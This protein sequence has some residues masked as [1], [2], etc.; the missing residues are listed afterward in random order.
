MAPATPFDAFWIFQRCGGY[1]VHVS[2]ICEAAT[3]PELTLS[4]VEKIMITDAHMHLIRPFDLEGNPQLYLPGALT[5]AKDYV[6]LMDEVGIER[7]FFISWSPEDISADIL[8]RGITVESLH[9]VMNREY[10]L[11]AMRAF[12][13]R[14][15]WF[16]CHLNP[17]TGDHLDIARE[18]LELGATGLKLAPS[19]WGELPD[20]PRLIPIYELAQDYGAQMIIDTSFWSLDEPVDPETFPPEHRIIADNLRSLQDYLKR[21]WAVVPAPGHREVAKRVKNFQD[22]IKHLEAVI[23]SYPDVNFQLAHAGARIYTPENVREV[24]K[25][26]RQHPN[27]FADL[28][29]LPIESLVP[30]YLVETAGADR[31]MFGTDWPHFA[32]GNEMREKIDQ[33]RNPGRFPDKVSEMILGE[34]ALRFLGGR[35]PGL[36]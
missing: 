15:Y 16:P 22:Y 20:D 12:P 5:D 21:L 23:T 32:Q 9:G 7:A 27:V 6:S 13:D 36:K 31:I 29:S 2:A 30:E 8:V 4:T 34:N 14:F 10:A 3:N 25:F 33:I 1:R 18:S 26:I 35:S 19:F 24:G 28:S 11:E 17:G